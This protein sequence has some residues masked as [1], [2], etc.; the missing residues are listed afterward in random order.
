[1][2]SQDNGTLVGIIG[3]LYV[4]LLLTYI[5]GNDDGRQINNNLL[6]V[7]EIIVATFIAF[8]AYKNNKKNDKISKF[9]NQQIN[10]VTDDVEKSLTNIIIAIYSTSYDIREL[11]KK[12]YDEMEV[13]NNLEKIQFHYLHNTIYLD[14]EKTRALEELIPNIKQLQQQ[15]GSIDVV[16]NNTILKL[17]RYFP[18]K[19]TKEINYLIHDYITKKKE[20]NPNF[21]KSLPTYKIIRQSYDDFV[22][23]SIHNAVDLCDSI[24]LHVKQPQ[25]EFVNSFIKRTTRHIELLQHIEKYDVVIDL[26]TH[27]IERIIKIYQHAKNIFE[28]NDQNNFNTRDFEIIIEYLKEINCDYNVFLNHDF[29]K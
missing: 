8:I 28:I 20:I 4:I 23:E 22:N 6:L 19:H 1:M 12:S 17:L 2:I 21:L 9:F 3:I 29:R 25:F 24:V 14:P 15:N 7:I 16:I 18:N 27:E 11:R 5:W 13:K 26:N 10:F